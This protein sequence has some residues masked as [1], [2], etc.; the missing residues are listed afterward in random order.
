MQATV[1]IWK[2]LFILFLGAR[3][4]AG[5]PAG[6]GV[7]MRQYI[8]RDVPVYAEVDVQALRRIIAGSEDMQKLLY[9][10]ADPAQ[11]YEQAAAQVALQAGVAAADVKRAV[12]S[13]RRIG[14]GLHA[15]G[16]D[17]ENLRVL[18]VLD[19]SGQQNLLAGL[20][21]GVA[22]T[23]EYSRSAYAGAVIHGMGEYEETVFMT[24]TNGLIAL[25]RDR[26]IVKDFLLKAQE[27]A[28]RHPG[29]GGRPG[30]VFY[31]EANG[32]PLLNTIFA[33]VES[34]DREEFL[35]AAAI[36]DL[37]SWQKL[38]LLYDGKQFKA[39]L[40]L[41]PA[42]RAA[43]VLVGPDK[44]PALA[45]ALPHD[46]PFAAVVSVKDPV[47]LYR[48]SLTG[49]YEAL[50]L[51]G[52]HHEIEEGLQEIQEE[53]G[54]D[55]ERDIFGNI[56]E[57]AFILTEMDEEGIMF[58][59][60]IKD[61]RKA[62]QAIW[63]WMQEMEGEDAES[64]N[65]K[66]AEVWDSIDVRIALYKN[67]FI[68]C[69]QDNRRFEDVLMQLGRGRSGVSEEL[70]GRYPKA[71]SAVLVNPGAMMGAKNSKPILAGLYMENNRLTL[72]AD[73][74]VNVVV[75]GLGKA[76]GKARGEAVR[77]KCMTNLR[78]LYLGCVMYANDN[79]DK[80]PATLDVLK[81][82]YI[83]A[84]QVFVCPQCGKPYIYAK[85]VAGKSLQQIANLG[86]TV[87]IHDPPGAHPGGGNAVYADGHAAWLDAQ[88]FQQAV[89][90]AAR[91]Q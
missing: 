63:A 13:I 8:A 79:D 31:A 34:Y 9:Q 77:V 6:E 5:V 51:E 85:A 48:A 21:D 23:E 45:A 75:K 91:A 3:P 46:V 24:E 49:V 70:A 20:L 1:P 88:Q 10:G 83:N 32:G 65:I 66:G 72:E 74:D 39:Q 52:E 12:E 4:L 18:C 55:I 54:M 53:I 22:G 81:P 60:R 56:T 64:T 35:M 27:A 37:A 2:L 87:I 36:M 15:F 25:G 42:G 57:A 7:S 44:Q 47:A 84:P 14:F 38:T 80:M 17:D 26:L 40:H 69:Q 62:H 67:T 73:L 89:K 78:Q 29:M 61:A 43:K 86:E 16:E 19:C 28:A 68:V 58:L 30:P 76:I 50:A 82:D 90:A 59:L 11:A 71:T 41:H 33:G